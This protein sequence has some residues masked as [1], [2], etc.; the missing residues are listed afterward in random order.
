MRAIG[1]ASR[2]RTAASR[3]RR[4]AGGLALALLAAC[5][6]PA[7]TEDPALASAV[8]RTAIASALVGAALD[9]TAAAGDGRTRLAALNRAAGAYEEAMA[10]MRLGLRLLSLRR[11]ALEERID[12]GRAASRQAIAMLAGMER[13]PAP[14]IL[15]NPAGPVGHLRAGHALAAVAPVL[16]ARAEALG[17]LAAEAAALD[18]A[19]AEDGAAVRAALSAAQEARAEQAAALRDGETGALPIPPARMRTLRA[20]RAASEKLASLLQKDPTPAAAAPAA[21]VWGSLPLP[22]AGRVTEG[23]GAPQPDGAAL[24]GLRIAAPALA[25]VTAPMDAA[26]RFAGPLDGYGEVAI[27][28]PEPGRL[29]VLAGLGAILHPQGAALRAGEVIARMGGADT[30]APEFLIEAEAAGG[31]RSDQTLYLETR[32]GGSPVD[33][34]RWFALGQEIGQE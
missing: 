28:E 23:W 25:P 32:E 11:A 26:L 22:L 21:T 16:R 1:R 6:A 2:R 31:A 17:A 14:A 5:P 18:A 13:T 4:L 27:L 20:G 33:P 12:A 8:E 19:I 30:A 9:E 7:Q 10:A 34:S 29:L 15:V 24:Q 3:P